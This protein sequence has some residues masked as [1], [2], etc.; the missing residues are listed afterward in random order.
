ME[1]SSPGV[2]S[3]PMELFRNAA[4]LVASHLV[5]WEMPVDHDLHLIECENKQHRHDE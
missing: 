2:W 1:R 5:D 4:S 3:E